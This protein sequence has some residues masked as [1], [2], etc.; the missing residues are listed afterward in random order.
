[1]AKPSVAFFAFLLLLF[2]LAISEI[3]TV[4]AELCEKASKTWS[5]TCRY[6]KHCDNQCKSWESAAHGACHVR[7]KKHMC[8][9]YF[10]CSKAQKLIELVLTLF[11]HVIG[12]SSIL[13]PN[14]CINFVIYKMPKYSFGYIAILFFVLAISEIQA[15]VSNAPKLCEKPSKTYSGLCF[16]YACDKKCMEWE[17]AF[18]G[19]CHTRESVNNCYCYYH[20]DKAPPATKPV[21]PEAMAPSPDASGGTGS[22]PPA[23]KIVEKVTN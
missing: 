15:A 12:A 3:A 9:C 16:N 6:T 7:K 5:G 14:G 20:C 11:L 19:A 1:M 13:G 17:A 10:H 2:I 22:P 4:K 21:P 18:H 23:K 8:F